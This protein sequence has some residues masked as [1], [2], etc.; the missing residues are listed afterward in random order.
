[1]TYVTV[2]FLLGYS[3]SGL[4]NVYN[5]LCWNAVVE[6]KVFSLF[7]SICIVNWLCTFQ[8]Y[9]SSNESAFARMQSLKHMHFSMTHREISI[10]CFEVLVASALWIYC[11]RQFCLL[12]DNYI[13]RPCGRGRYFWCNISNKWMERNLLA[14]LHVLPHSHSDI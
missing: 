10:G 9:E 3:V 5:L 7:Q 1:M 11:A 13:S 8:M 2:A 12:S 6:T 14:K 4:S